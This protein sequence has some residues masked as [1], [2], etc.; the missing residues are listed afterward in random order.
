MN[1]YKPIFKP[2]FFL[3]CTGLY[4]M[5]DGDLLAQHEDFATLL[6]MLIRELYE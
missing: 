4:V 2:T 5:L 1:R 3:G 6:E